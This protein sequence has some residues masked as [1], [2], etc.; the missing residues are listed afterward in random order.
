MNSKSFGNEW[1]KLETKIRGLTKR[2]PDPEALEKS[3]GKIKAHLD[4]CVKAA[5]NADSRLKNFRDEVQG[6]LDNARTLVKHMERLKKLDAEFRSRSEGFRELEAKTSEVC[7][8]YFDRQQEYM[9]ARRKAEER[10]DQELSNIRAEFLEKAESIARGYEVTVDG[11][12]CSPEALYEGL[13]DQNLGRVYL[14]PKSRGKA[15]LGKLGEK[16]DKS[17]AKEEV[18]RYLVGET[19]R[20]IAPMLRDKQER[21]DG[22]NRA[23]PDLK[24][25]EAECKEA[26]KL[27]V[28]AEKQI[29]ELRVEMLGI[30][31]S[32]AFAYSK[33]EKLQELKEGYLSRIGEIEGG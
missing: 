26:E 7:G 33:K 27:R 16:E 24:A 5:K 2:P 32:K 28:K 22:V 25:R 13:K 31:M 8:K 12:E 11:E 15:F 29:E 10:V 1:K 3:L 23:F 19:A 30:R 20:K 18:L 4:A 21:I 6:D 14:A 17:K 9:R